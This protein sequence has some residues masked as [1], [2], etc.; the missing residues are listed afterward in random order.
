MTASWLDSVSKVHFSHEVGSFDYV[1]EM[2]VED[3]QVPSD[4]LQV[5][6]DRSKVMDKISPDKLQ[7]L[8][9]R[10]I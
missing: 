3:C 9:N 8:T 5:S 1:R 4:L 10:G 6:S 2:H 7:P